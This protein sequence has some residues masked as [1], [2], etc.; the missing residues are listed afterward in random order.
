MVGQCPSPVLQSYQETQALRNASIALERILFT[1]KK[2]EVKL[3]IA[4]LLPS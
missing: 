3:L 1:Y 4:L 2:V